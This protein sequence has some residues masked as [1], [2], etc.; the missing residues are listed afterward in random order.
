MARIHTIPMLS[1]LLAAPLVAT[2]ATTASSRTTGTGAGAWAL[3]ASGAPTGSV[4]GVVTL[5][6]A[7]PRSLTLTGT[8]TPAAPALPIVC[9]GC[10]AGN[11]T[12]TLD[13]GVGAGPDYFVMGSYFGTSLTGDGTFQGVIREQPFPVRRPV[14]EIAGKFRDLPSDRAP[15]NFVCSVVI[16]R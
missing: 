7:T 12:G 10:I 9:L 14:G 8:L 11:F 13:D 1:F 3:P 6:G 2:G 5:D 15:G 16:D 4:L